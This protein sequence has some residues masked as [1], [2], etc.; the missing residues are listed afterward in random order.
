MILL[1]LISSKP[2]SASPCKSRHLQD[3][4]W[5][6]LH[7][8]AD[9]FEVSLRFGYFEQLVLL[10]DWPGVLNGLPH[11][12]WCL[13]RFEIANFHVALVLFVSGSQKDCSSL[14]TNSLFKRVHVILFVS[15]IQHGS[16]I[17][18]W[19]GRDFSEV[20]PNNVTVHFL[21]HLVRCASLLLLLFSRCYV[22]SLV[23]EDYCEFTEYSLRMFLWLFKGCLC[24]FSSTSCWF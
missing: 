7:L 10:L 9:L 6:R 8:A 16:P 15:Q 23:L 18:I 21:V 2:C 3:L 13:F 1:A 24:T 20:A 11:L 17:C 4:M 19:K 22:P 14:I 12:E 5:Y